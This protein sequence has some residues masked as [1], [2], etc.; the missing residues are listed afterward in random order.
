MLRSAGV[1]V[2]GP[3]LAEVH[4]ER[5]EVP[6]RRADPARPRSRCWPGR[7]R[8]A[9]PGA[10]RPRGRGGRARRRRPGRPGTGSPCTPDRRRRPSPARGWRAPPPGWSGSTSICTLGVVN[11]V[12]VIS[13]S[14]TPPSARSR[15]YHSGSAS[16]VARR[17]PGVRRS[18]TWLPSPAPLSSC[19]ITTPATWGRAA[20][21]DATAARTSSIVR[22]S[23]QPDRHRHAGLLEQPA[24]GALE[25]ERPQPRRRAVDRRVERQRHRHL[26]V[27]DVPRLDEGRPSRDQPS[28]LVDQVGPVEEL[29]GD[30][31][32]ARVGH[33]EHVEARAGRRPPLGRDEREVVVEH[34]GGRRLAHHEHEVAGDAVEHQQRQQVAVLERRDPVAVVRQQR[35]AEAE[36]RERDDHVLVVTPGLAQRRG[37]GPSRSCSASKV[38]SALGPSSRC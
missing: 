7:A 13:S 38:A 33:L 28:Q 4:L 17:S 24:P 15:R 30:R 6:A 20:R 19:L 25:A 34:L 1:G 26:V 31:P 8:R 22:T 27:G 37:R 14:T 23:S 35:L 36:R 2:G 5:V 9:P 3:A 16:S 11:R 18:I 29:L 32:V 10:P 21:T 12:P